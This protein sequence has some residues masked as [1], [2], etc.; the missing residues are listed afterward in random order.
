MKLPLSSSLLAA[1]VAGLL[2]NPVLGQD[3][4]TSP[5][6]TVRTGQ[7]KFPAP[8]FADGLTIN[9]YSQLKI[10]DTYDAVYKAIGSGCIISNSG[11]TRYDKEGKII[12]GEVTFMHQIAGVI[13]VII[14]DDKLRSKSF[15]CGNDLKVDSSQPDLIPAFDFESCPRKK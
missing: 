2:T 10:D 6:E 11:N 9:H 13:K 1:V 5:S 15:L 4:S 7:R 14:A 8:E 3:S 12:W